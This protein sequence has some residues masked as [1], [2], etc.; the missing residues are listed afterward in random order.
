MFS[1]AIGLVSFPEAWL[2]TDSSLYFINHVQTEL[3]FS[4]QLK[5]FPESF[6]MALAHFPVFA[7]PLV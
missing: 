5:Y 3:S 4:E 1:N 6:L 2:H 7:F